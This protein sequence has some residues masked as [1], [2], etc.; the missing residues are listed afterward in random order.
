MLPTLH[1]V[2]NFN[3][4]IVLADGD[5]KLLASPLAGTGLKCIESAPQSICVLVG[6]EGGISDNEEQRALEAGFALVSMGN[7]ILR[8]ETSPAAILSL[9]QYHWGDF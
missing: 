9:M 1:E 8:A 5:L 7:R 3:Q 4:W 2:L 6:P